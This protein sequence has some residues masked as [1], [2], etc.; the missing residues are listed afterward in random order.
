MNGERQ[1]F[2]NA[3]W[4]PLLVTGVIVG[5][6]ALQ[7][8]G[9]VEPAAYRFGFSA[10]KL[11]AGDWPSLITAL[12][13]HGSWMH[14][15]L[16]AAF[17]LAFGAP[18]ARYLGLSASAI[19]GFFIFYFACGAVANLGYAAL[20]A[21]ESTPLIG[22]SGAV[23][24]LMGAAARLIATRGARL[25]PLTSPPVISMSL[26]LLV[27]NLLLAVFGAPGAGGAA[28]AWEAH[29]VGFAAGLLSIG[30][31]TRLFGRRG[32]LPH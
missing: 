10:A 12:F 17:A 7:S 26:A 19:A 5:L 25:G 1:P 18:V 6:Y 15:L 13:V 30:L 29:L 32:R 16:N 22:A 20:N 21:G 27:V 2:F 4:P 3:P 28:I 9:P 8:L 11:D 24:G 14:A 23:A 31:I